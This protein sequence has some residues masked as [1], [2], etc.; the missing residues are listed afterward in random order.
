VNIFYYALC[1][2]ILSD[3]LHFAKTIPGYDVPAL[4]ESLDWVA[5]MTYDYHGQWDK[6]T[7]HVAPMYFHPEDDFYFFNAVSTYSY[8]VT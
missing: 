7:G 4:A 1:L 5:V 3:K 2:I 6:K 8:C